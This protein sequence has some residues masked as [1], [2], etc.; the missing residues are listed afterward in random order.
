MKENQRLR[1]S[2][3]RLR[4]HHFQTCQLIKTLHTEQ[5]VPSLKPGA[6]GCSSTFCIRA[7]SCSHQLCARDVL[8]FTGALGRP[9][10]PALVVGCP[11][12]LGASCGDIQIFAGWGFSWQ[13]IQVP[14]SS[15]SAPP[16]VPRLQFPPSHPAHTASRA[17]PHALTGSGNVTP[18]AAATHVWEWMRVWAHV[19]A[20]PTHL[21][22]ACCRRVPSLPAMHPVREGLLFLL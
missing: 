1:R 11:R 17:L 8:G 5:L 21:P 7:P 22:P 20:G 4:L 6:E 18:R 12:A 13:L 2:S 3:V 14:P 19:G 10:A 16:E 9:P 15:S